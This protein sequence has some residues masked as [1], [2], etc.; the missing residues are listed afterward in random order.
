[1]R[2][3]A[4]TKT[5]LLVDDDE[6]SRVATRRYLATFGYAVDAVH[7]AKEA[8]ALFNP[9]THDLVLTDNSMPG[10][11]GAELAHVLKLRSPLTPVVMYSS[12]PPKNP[13]GLDLVLRKPADLSKLRDSFARLLPGCSV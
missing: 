2:M 9:Q 5:I 11:S 13:A 1:M 10:M 4:V 6:V 7:G 12:N 3:E 8:L